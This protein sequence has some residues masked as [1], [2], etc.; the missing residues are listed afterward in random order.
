MSKQKSPLVLGPA[1][2]LLLLWTPLRASPLAPFL[3]KPVSVLIRQHGQLVMQKPVPVVTDTEAQVRAHLA[4][5]LDEQWKHTDVDAQTELLVRHGFLPRGTDVRRTL[6]DLF[7]SQ[8]AAFYDTR[9]GVFHN[10]H[11]GGATE[12]L[13]EFVVVAHELTH[14]AQDQTVPAQ[15]RMDQVQQDDDQSRALMWALEGQATLLGNRMGHILGPPLP[16]PW[17]AALGELE[18]FFLWTPMFRDAAPQAMQSTGAAN[19][20]PFMLEQ[21]WT[22]Y[23]LGSRWMWNV[24]RMLGRAAHRQVLCHPPQSTHQ[25]LH[26]RA[27]AQRVPPL[28]VE[29][30]PRQGGA[31]RTHLVQGE[32]ALRWLLRNHLA[33]K[34]ADALAQSW[35]GDSMVLAA[36]GSSAWRVVTS[37][38]QDAVAL[39][40][41]L[42]GIPDLRTAQVRVHGDEVH[43]FVNIAAEHVS[44]WHAE[45]SSS[46][47]APLV[48]R[49]GCP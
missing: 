21:L 3:V 18:T 43:L 34:Q 30:A 37:T 24:E 23:A 31:A 29:A 36:D 15:A 25:T 7:G 46:S 26:P 47:R 14:A 6:L 5:E 22:P 1:L 33:E 28:V 2:C 45:L 35:R 40:A 48:S 16:G 11:R 9:T 13:G 17:G 4:K 10:I 27:Y 44:A 42:Q 39:G 41:A 8:A 38:P 20:P 12:A 19:V 32:W 49:S